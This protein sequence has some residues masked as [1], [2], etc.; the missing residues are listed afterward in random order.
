MNKNLYAGSKI[1]LVEDEET[2]A[3]GLKYNLTED[4]YKVIWAK[5]GKKALDF[6]ATRPIP[7][8]GFS[9]F[10]SIDRP[11]SRKTHIIFP[12]FNN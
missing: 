4:G 7:F 1:L 9:I 2:L 12:D 3:V 6:F 10:P 5:N 11:P 8:L